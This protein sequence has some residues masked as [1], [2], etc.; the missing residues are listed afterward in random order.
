MLPK[1]DLTGTRPLTSVAP[2]TPVPAAGDSR[3]E[4]FSR[5]SQ[6]AVGKTVQADVLSRLDER[7]Y[8]V[9][10]ADTTVRAS[11][12]NGAR[13]GDSLNV[14]LIAAEPRPTFLLLSGA[15]ADTTSLS[16]AGRL[17]DNVLSS[18]RRG[19]APTAL[20][21]NKAIVT[22]ATASTVEIA[23][24]LRN[25]LVFSGLFYESHLKQWIS[26][27]RPLIHLQQEPQTAL[28]S[29]PARQA[30]ANAGTNAAAVRT[31]L[32][33]LIDIVGEWADGRTDTAIASGQAPGLPVGPEMADSRLM[34]LVNLQ[35]QTLENN[36]VAWH[37]E[38]WPG[39]PM[40]WEIS[41]DRPDETQSG[42]EE[43]ASSWTSVVRFEL[44][45]LG[46]IA[47]TIQLTGER[48]TMQVRTASDKAT[49]ALRAHGSEL[50]SALDAAGA[51]LDSL[52]V[53]HDEQA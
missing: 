32:V 37:G 40:E 15:T 1:A 17:I 18:A 44:P 21:G 35:L 6:I 11:L 26:G 47:A 7:T 29:D 36:R 25:A 42:A 45:T 22:A 20:T 16:N 24:A 10:I 4:I 34:Q 12:P 8:M 41:E 28:H 13:V 39:Q 9:K 50:A 38:L 49:V 46:T 23:G 14:R 5:L 30:A 48:V 33:Q 53:Q 2:V 3:Q 27:E 51:P 31:S 19:D 52:T 43:Q